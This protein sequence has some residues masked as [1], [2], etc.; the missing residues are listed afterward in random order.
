MKQFFPLMILVTGCSKPEVY[1][2]VGGH[3]TSA[4]SISQKRAKSLNE[5]ENQEIKKWITLSNK[6]FYPTKLNYWSNIKGLSDRVKK[7]DGQ[8]VSYSY[9][10]YDFDWIKIYTTP[11][12]NRNVVLGKFDEIKA[13]ENALRYLQ[14]NEETIL[15]VP[16]A[17]AYGTYGDEKK[18]PNDMPL[19]IK[20]KLLHTK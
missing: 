13:I 14:T 15:L 10:I 9:E 16:S 8:Q 18:I 2:P 12:E 4:I 5:W 19:I 17:L 3:H 20:L 7:K 11:I 1:P 6:D